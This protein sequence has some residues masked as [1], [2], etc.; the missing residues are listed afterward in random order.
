MISVVLALY[1]GQKYILQQLESLLNQTVK[2]DEVI[3]CDDCS[4]DNSVEL[5]RKFIE[6]NHLDGWRVFENS[7][8]VGYCRNFYRAL[9]LSHGDYIFFCDQDDVWDSEKIEVLVRFLEKNKRFSAIACNYRL[10]DS[11]GEESPNLTVPH[12]N[13]RFDGTLDE[14][15]VESLIGHSYIRGCALCIRKEIKEKVCPI[16]LKDLLGHDWQ[17]VMLC[18]LEGK[19]ALLNTA[20][21][22]YRC[23]ENNASFSTSPSRLLKKRVDGLLQSIEGHSYILSLCNNTSVKRKIEKFIEFE[24]K[25]VKFLTTKNPLTFISL[26]FDLKEYKRYYGKNPLKVYLGDLYYINKK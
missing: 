6:D 14:I 21:M 18:A 2:P 17:I 1:N 12:Y 4:T 25:R 13:P 5:C 24:K 11:N 19:A 16:E 15:K 7:E 23:H 20:L 8:N 10:I 9:E 22:G 26:G 3:I